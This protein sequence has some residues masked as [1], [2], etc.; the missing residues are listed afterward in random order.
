MAQTAK[1]TVSSAPS[2][3]LQELVL[4][5]HLEA[6]LPLG[7]LDLADWVS[8]FSD[9]PLVQELSALPRA[10][11]HV[12][13]VVPGIEISPGG[14]L[15]RIVLRS[16][17]GRYIAQLQ[18][19]RFAFGWARTEPIGVAA[20]YPGFEEMTSRWSTMFARF[21]SWAEK[22]FRAKPRIRMMELTYL[23]AAPLQEGE[24][25]F[26]ISE[27]FKFVQPTG[28]PIGTFAVSWTELVYPNDPSDQ[29]PRGIVTANVGLGQAPP[30]IPV[31]VF[32]FS[33]LAAVAE[34]KQNEQILKDLHSAI[35][36]VYLSAIKSNGN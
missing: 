6:P 23:N 11:L 26:R 28:R 21:E 10:D 12:F 19:D 32:N 17:D 29:P 33:G 7:V 34:G 36:V 3:T 2:T 14:V 20:E 8:T 22:R 30:G 35:R 1:A 4:V 5:A 15:P 27:I 31:L 9:Y 24:R 13:G 25:K 16:T 18:G